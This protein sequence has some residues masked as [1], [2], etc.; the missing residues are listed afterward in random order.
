MELIIFIENDKET[1]LAHGE[2]LLSD[3][4]RLILKHYQQPDP[5]G[6]PNVPIPDP[7]TVP[8]LKHSFS[9]L[10]INLK[11]V[12]VHGLSKFRIIRAESE[13][14]LMQVSFI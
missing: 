8:D 10:T 9:M 5:I 14:A 4:I 11:S 1:K 2:Q 7:M 6:L 3:Q 12:T 13:I